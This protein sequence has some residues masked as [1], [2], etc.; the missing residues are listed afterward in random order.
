MFLEEVGRRSH[1]SYKG[2][3]N[4][5]MA[6]MIQS[7]PG[8]QATAKQERWRA[9]SRGWLCGYV[10]SYSL[11]TFGVYTSFMS[12]NTTSTGMD[13]GQ[14]KLLGAA[15]SF[16]P[17]PLFLLGAFVGSLLQPKKKEPEMFR[18]SVLVAL[19][20]SAGALTSHLAA[21]SWICVAILS[22]AMGMMNTTLSHVGGQSVNLGFVTGDLKN[23]GGHLADIVNRVPLPE[24][25]GK[26]DTH[27]SRAAILT[28]VWTSF[29]VGAI[30][31][32]IAAVR[33]GSWTLLVPALLLLALTTTERFYHAR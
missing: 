28:S 1:R 2:D 21:S 32:A 23:L 33:F 7:G 30:F 9:L 14:A 22:T 31:G 17:I 8:V 11:L 20:L 15:H 19:L 18:V 24:S 29:L 10:D 3:V 25:A 16:L 12:G 26:W 13:A 6:T 4:L 27:W 5:T